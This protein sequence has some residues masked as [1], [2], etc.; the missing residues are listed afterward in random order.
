MAQG[1]DLPDRSHGAAL[2]V[3]I[4]GFTQLTDNLITWL[5]D[6]RGIDELTQLLNQVYGV[7]IA[8]VHRYGGSV[9]GFSGDAITCWFAPSFQSAR[10][11]QANENSF[12]LSALRGVACALAIQE[13]VAQFQAVKTPSGVAM[14]LGV[15]AALEVGP[16]RRFVV[17]DPAIQQIDVLAGATLDRMAQAEKLAGRGEVILGPEATTLLVDIIIIEA[18]RSPN[19]ETPPHFAVISALHQP[20]KPSPWPAPLIDSLPDGSYPLSEDQVRPWLL[21]LIYERLQMTQDHF[22]A[23]LRR[24]I[25]LFILFSGIDYDH[26]QEAKAKLDVYVRWVQH[27]VARFGGHL[28]QLTTGDKGS[29]LYSSFGAPITHG[30]D[31]IRAVAAAITLHHPPENLRYI[32]DIRIGLSQGRMRAGPSGSAARRTYGVL[33]DEV[34]MAARLMELAQPGQILISERVAAALDNR[35]QLQNLGRITVRGRQHPFSIFAV[36]NQKPPALER[37]GLLRNHWTNEPEYLTQISQLFDL[38]Q[39]AQGQILHLTV[40]DIDQKRAHRAYLVQL[41]Q[42]RGFNIATADGNRGDPDTAYA[43]WRPLFARYIG[44]PTGLPTPSDEIPAD[45]DQTVA[46]Q[47]AHLTSWIQQTNPEWLTLLPLFGEFLGLPIPENETTRQLKLPQLRQGAL[48]AVVLEVVRH[49]AQ[50]QPVL[51]LLNHMDRIDEASQQITFVLTEIAADLPLLLTLIQTPDERASDFLSIRQRSRLPYYLRLIIAGQTEILPSVPPQTAPDAETAP[52]GLT[53]LKS[54]IGRQEERALLVSR[55]GGLTQ[56]GPNWSGIVVGEAGIGKTHLI[57]DALRRADTRGV[58][59]L[60][61]AGESLEQSTPYHAWRPVFRRLFHF[62]VLSDDPAKRTTHIMARISTT[63]D[64]DMLQ[65]APL[66]NAVLPLELPDNEF[67]GQ[68]RGQ[69]RAN[70]TQTLL[71]QLLQRAA[72]QQPLILIIEDAHW[73]DSAS[74]ALLQ[75]VHQTV[76]PLALLIITRPLT[77]PIPPEYS[78]IWQASTSE[79]IELDTLSEAETGQLVTQQLGGVSTLPPG[80]VSLIQARTEGHPFFT[81]ELTNALLETEVITV[82]NGVCRLNAPTQDLD[83]IAVPDTIEGIITSRIDHLEPAQQLALKIASVIGRVF[84]FST[85]Y[86]VHPVQRERMRL[87]TDLETLQRL[88]ITLIETPEP[89]LSYIFKHIITQEVAYNMMIADQRQALHQGVATWYEAHHQNNLEPWYPLLAHHWR[90]ANNLTKAI[91]Y[92]EKAGEQALIDGAYKEAIRFFQEAIALLPVLEYQTEPVQIAT[93][94][95]YLGEAF[96]GLGQLVESRQCFE[97]ALRILDRPVPRTNRQAMFSLIKQILQQVW[98]RVAFFKIGQFRPPGLASLVLTQDSTAQAEYTTAARAYEQLVEIYYYANDTI[99]SA[100]AGMQT[101]NLAEKSGPS[102][103]LVRAYANLTVGTG[104]VPVHFLARFYSYHAKLLTRKFRDQPLRAFV[105]ARTSLYYLVCG[106]WAEARAAQ[107]QAISLSKRLQDRRQLGEG[108]ILLGMTHYAQ[109]QFEQS[110]ALFQEL[111]ALGLQTGNIQHQGWAL[112]GLGL[113]LWQRGQATEAVQ[114]LEQAQPIFKLSADRV[115]EIF[116]YEVLALAHLRSGDEQLA[117]Q[118]N[119]AASR[120]IAESPPT[121][122]S[123]F[124]DYI[125]VALVYLTLWE[126]AAQRPESEQ[127]LYRQFAR[128]AYRVLR[129]YAW[130][131]PVGRPRILLTLGLY[132]WLNGKPAKA[133]QH[134]HKGLAFAQKLGQPYEQALLHYEIGRHLPPTDPAF[135]DHLSQAKDLF[136]RL[137]SPYDLAQVE[138]TLKFI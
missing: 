83:D 94:H 91:S 48:F 69:V 90:E 59:R 29:Y 127:R 13:M 51:M 104:L 78:L 35:F 76:Q 71:V 56:Q 39:A 22:L 109:G 10:S 47:I 100:N 46:A 21:P 98:H 138:Q 28:I 33:G 82:S 9:I 70:N 112:N 16:A 84:R 131:F 105:Q 122:L 30:D 5:G 130:V 99:A 50:I 79:Y 118:T 74:W 96:L 60:V 45:Q 54:L 24:T 121:P 108:L 40:A 103:A 36:L 97:E 11:N 44:L 134:W 66:L 132:H 85:L 27:Q 57:I 124:A 123:A 75:Q 93:W 68:M 129:I 125:G 62:D 23:D 72:A 110:Q 81:E 135:H 3:D 52:G 41:A 32:T 37:S 17:G 12:R 114:L 102:P 67:T 119:E 133:M 117:R 6:R 15:K 20:V 87:Q 1:F 4:S 111:H 34:N 73:L 116:C 89:E 58:V 42:Q 107:E 113:L 95:R 126:A 101:L 61:G 64:P 115:A 7:L 18:R 2:F 128:R 19:A 14:S 55:L 137:D 38:A 31:A 25:P 88:E 43:F 8:E 26:D 106:K 86:D 49:A 120:L 136:S 53:P 65:R 77:P 80:V 92:L 63:Q